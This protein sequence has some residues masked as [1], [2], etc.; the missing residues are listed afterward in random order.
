LR[1][2]DAELG[3][4]GTACCSRSFTGTKRM[5]GLITASQIA[6]ASAAPFLLR[7]TQAFT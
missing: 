7:F 5:V 3:K 6:S 1:A 2:N 4:A